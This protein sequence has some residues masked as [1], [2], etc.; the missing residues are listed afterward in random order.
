MQLRDYQLD[1]RASVH[2]SWEAHESTMVSL[3]T[4]MGKT[5]IFVS[6]AD[7]WRSREIDNYRVLVIAPM[8]ELVDQAAEKLYRRTGMMPGIEQGGRRSNETDW[9]RSHF[10]VASKQTLTG[11]RK[12]YQRLRDVGMVVVDECHLAATK[13][14]ADMIGHFRDLG[15][16]V[17]GLTATPKRHDNRAMGQLFDDCCFNM[18]IREAI[19][20]GWLVPPKTQCLQLQNLDLSEVGTGGPEGDFKKGELGEAMEDEKVVFE[21]AEVTAR[22]SGTL[23]TAVFCATVNEARAVAGLLCD[24]HSLKAEWV[25]GD[26]KLCTPEKRKRVLHGFTRGDIQVACNVGVLT[27]GWDFPGLEHIVVARPTKSLPLYTQILGRG[28]RPLPGVVDFEGSTPELRKQAIASSSKPHFVVTDL[29]D[30]SLHHKLVTATDVLGG[31]MTL[32]AQERAVR[33]LASGGGPQDLLS[34]L[35]AAREAQEAQEREERERRARYRAQAEFHRLQVDP[36]NES[37]RANVDHSRKRKGAKMPFGKFKGKPIESLPSWYLDWGVKN[38]S[39]GWV[40]KAMAAEQDRRRGAAQA[41]AGGSGLEDINA[42]LLE[43]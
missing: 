18:G 36:F 5:E 2:G 9:G 33:E 32:E 40:K 30:N 35:D 26:T 11:K 39:K 20:L 1:A 7:E 4:G 24:Q 19:D 29:R 14:Y 17:L 10:V 27:T 34:V 43:R 12:R 21:I 6:V 15:A 22:E 31:E 16:K 8:I 38:V 13:P 23:K 28:T 42:M 41:P 25:C 3:P 37:Q